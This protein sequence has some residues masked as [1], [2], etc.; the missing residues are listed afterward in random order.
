MGYH[1]LALASFTFY[2]LHPSPSSLG[3]FPQCPSTYLYSRVHLCHYFRSTRLERT[4]QCVTLSSP[5]DVLL[6]IRIPKQQIL[7]SNHLSGS[8]HSTIPLR[9]HSHVH[10]TSFAS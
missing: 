5:F 1:S 7:L 8:E 2:A 3:S 10:D 4:K 6:M 9:V